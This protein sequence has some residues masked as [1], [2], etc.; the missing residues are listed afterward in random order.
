M[1]DTGF[2]G[3]WRPGRPKNRKIV[4]QN[5]LVAPEVPH[6]N[7][8]DSTGPAGLP[9]NSTSASSPR[10]YYTEDDLEALGCESPPDLQRRLRCL[11]GSP[12]PPR[13]GVQSAHRGSPGNARKSV[14][15]SKVALDFLFQAAEFQSSQPQPQDTLTALLKPRVARHLQAEGVR[16]SKIFRSH[17]PARPHL[18]ASHPTPRRR[19]SCRHPAL[20][21]AA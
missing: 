21:Q 8:P 14:K 20:G 6:Y 2:T 12:D 16:T 11:G 1:S 18:V 7:G 13:I 5:T 10:N 3:S 4:A 15:W 17:R 9:T 19:K